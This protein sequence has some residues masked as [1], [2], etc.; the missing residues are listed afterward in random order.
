MN[1]PRSRQAAALSPVQGLPET[2]GFSLRMK[3]GVAGKIK[4]RSTP[5]G[6]LRCL[7]GGWRG[8][9]RCLICA[10]KVRNAAQ[11]LASPRAVCVLVRRDTLEHAA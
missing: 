4:G 8:K 3:N 11:R 5:G 10:A 9:L 7:H 6:R 2:R 1:S